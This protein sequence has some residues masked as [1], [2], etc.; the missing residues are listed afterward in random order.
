MKQVLLL[1]M[2]E[3]IFPYLRKYVT[4]GLLPNFA[5][6]F[7]DYGYVE[8]SSEDRF[9]E[10]EPWIQ[11][12]SIHTG[13]RLKEHGV[14]RLGDVVGRRLRQIWEHLEEKGLRV[15]AISPMNAENALKNPSFF[16]PDP[17]TETQGSGSFLFLKVY[18]A[19]KQ[20]V[21]DNAQRRLTLATALYLL[22]GW[23]YYSKVTSLPAYARALLYAARGHGW[24]QAIFLDRFL[25]DIFLQLSQRERPQFA[26]LFLNAAAHIQHHY[27]YNSSAYDGQ[28]ENPHWYMP[29]GL[30]P[31]L[32]AYRTYDGIVGDALKLPEMPRVM[33]ATGLQQEAHGN[34]T[35]FYRLVDHERFFRDVGIRF[36]KINTL[37]SRDFVIDFDSQENAGSAAAILAESCDINGVHLFTVDNRGTSLFVELIYSLEV[38]PGLEIRI[39]SCSV[40][41]FEQH[42]AFVAIRNGQHN[43]TGYFLDTGNRA[44][45][46]SSPM[47]VTDIWHV[48]N[49]AVTV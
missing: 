28:H 17:W 39:G 19:I 45:E 37:M 47:P 11:W 5:M 42:V 31:L 36:T 18:Q 49:N 43:G 7:R 1:E 6:L 22:I 21:N 27:L 46:N 3:I 20:A 33:I 8:T 30:D 24:G 14:F 34:V 4:R 32:E 35:Y 23:L 44:P 41:D 15:G 48:I 16:M 2:N 25:A 40:K 9:S 10:I 12:V 38:K 26:S 29:K 13:K